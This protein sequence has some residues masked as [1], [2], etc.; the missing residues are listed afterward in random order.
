M[1]VVL[2]SI[3]IVLCAWFMVGYTSSEQYVSCD[4]CRKYKRTIC[5]RSTLCW[6]SLFDQKDID[7]CVA[8]CKDYNCET[9]CAWPPM[10]V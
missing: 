8:S 2:A 9:A 7:D 10:L 1:L 4:A 3:V 5:G 6:D